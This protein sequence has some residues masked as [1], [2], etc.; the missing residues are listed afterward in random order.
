MA[1]KLDKKA[2]AD[3]LHYADDNLG[4]EDQLL[5]HL[6]ELGGGHVLRKILSKYRKNSN[7]GLPNQAVGEVY[8]LLDLPDE[9]K[10]AR[11]EIEKAKSRWTSGQQEDFRR[12]IE[13]LDLALKHSETIGEIA[14]E[15]SLDLAQ[16]DEAARKA[17]IEHA[18][19]AVAKDQNAIESLIFH[20]NAT[21]QR[22]EASVLVGWLFPV[23]L[24]GNAG[25]DE[26]PATFLSFLKFVHQLEH[27][28]PTRD[29]LHAL[30][31]IAICLSI[32]RKLRFEAL[33]QYMRDHRITQLPVVDVGISKQIVCRALGRM[34]KPKNPEHLR[35]HIQMRIAVTKEKIV[36]V[37]LTELLRFANAN[38]IGEVQEPAG[39]TLS[40]KDFY[41]QFTQ[42]LAKAICLPIE[43]ADK[44]GFLAEINSMLETYAELET[45]IFVFLNQRRPEKELEK[46]EKDFP[47][48]EIVRLADVDPPEIRKLRNNVQFANTLLDSRLGSTGTTDII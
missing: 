18:I 41:D 11:A 22:P 6:L 46:L 47:L 32:P 2:T 1:A 37:D 10:A 27:P 12:F 19:G 45:K 48:L 20:F 42:G 5:K 31:D 25:E 29:T 4:P 8:M 44:S 13:L 35:A 17:L 23:E 28:L 3:Q 21:K 36:D 33:G 39:A 24:E 15:P 40:A 9:A 7:R 14:A 30:R 16:S 34:S 38:V 43:K 26:A